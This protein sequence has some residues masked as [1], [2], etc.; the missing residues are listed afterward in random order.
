MALPLPELFGL[1]ALQGLAALLLLKLIASEAEQHD[2]REKLQQIIV[3][4]AAVSPGIE[5]RFGL[6]PK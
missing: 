3:T 2:I 5:D 1:L 6:L 4:V